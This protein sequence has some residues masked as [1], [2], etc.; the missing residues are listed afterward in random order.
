MPSAYAELGETCAATTRR[1]G[2]VVFRSP[3]RRSY[4]SPSCAHQKLREV[5]CRL[6]DADR[7]F[8]DCGVARAETKRKLPSAGVVATSEN[9]LSLRIA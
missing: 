1:Y 4:V 9:D 3:L 7:A 5:S 8:F 6:M 2:I